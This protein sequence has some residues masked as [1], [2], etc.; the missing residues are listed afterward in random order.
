[1]NLGRVICTFRGHSFK[2]WKHFPAIGSVP[3]FR[4]RECRRCGKTE[5]GPIPVRTPMTRKTQL[6]EANEASTRG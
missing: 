6:A 4:M 2:R 3:A 1:M 5:N